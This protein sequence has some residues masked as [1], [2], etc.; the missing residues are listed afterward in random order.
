MK[1]KTT[2]KEV[3]NTFVKGKNKEET[4]AKY[5]QMVS[6]LFEARATEEVKAQNKFR[7]LRLR[8]C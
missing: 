7:G 5:H 3:K 1:T 6:K 2:L 8:T 4:L